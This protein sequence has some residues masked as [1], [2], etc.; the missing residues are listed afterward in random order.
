MDWQGAIA[1]NPPTS[2]T[3]G[4]PSSRQACTSIPHEPA[5]DFRAAG[6]QR[7][8]QIRTDG[9]INQAEFRRAR[10]TATPMIIRRQSERGTSIERPRNSANALK[11]LARLRNEVLQIASLMVECGV[12]L[13]LITDKGRDG[14][15]SGNR[16]RVR[17]SVGRCRNSLRCCGKAGAVS[18]VSLRFGG[19]FG[20]NRTHPEPLDPLGHHHFYAQ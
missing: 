2:P 1:T 9:I 10:R 17:S 18:F 5:C 13:L 12:V 16:H 11:D 4:M 15:I 3:T 8:P 19:A 6:L 14:W 7:D 20:A